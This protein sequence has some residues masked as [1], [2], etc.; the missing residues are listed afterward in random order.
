M[1]SNVEGVVDDVDQ[2]CLGDSW[3]RT[4]SDFVVQSWSRLPPRSACNGGCC[5][6]SLKV[7]LILTGIHVEYWRRNKREITLFAAKPSKLCKIPQHFSNMP[8]ESSAREMLHKRTRKQWNINSGRL[9]LTVLGDFFVYRVVFLYSGVRFLLVAVRVYCC[10]ALW[11]KFTS[12]L[13]K[14]VKQA[15]LFRQNF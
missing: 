6:R 9:I 8:F 7:W 3:I 13:K 5:V 11:V 2:F 1:N 14:D 10:S 15:S 4:W 12:L